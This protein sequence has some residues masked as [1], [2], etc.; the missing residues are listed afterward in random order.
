MTAIVGDT[1][2]LIHANDLE[3]NYIDLAEQNIIPQTRNIENSGPLFM[4]H[5]DRH[6]NQPVYV[7]FI[8]LFT[9]DVS[10]NRSKSWNKHINQYFAHRNLP[11][12]IVNQEFHVHFAS[13]S[14][15]VSATEQFAAIKEMIEET[16][17]DP[18]VTV[19]AAT[20]QL[21]RVRLCLISLAADNPMA[22]E[23]GCHIGG[24][25]NH[26]CRRCDVGGTT[27]EKMTE[28]GYHSLFAP[29]TPRTKLHIIHALKRQVESL[30]FDTESATSRLQTLSGIK[31]SF[32]T[33]G[34]RH[35]I[36]RMNEMQTTHSRERLQE[37]LHDIVHKPENESMLFNPV[38]TL[39]GFD[40]AIDTPIEILHTILLGIVKY[41]WHDTY[42]NVLS[43]SG[44]KER[45]FV[46]HLKCINRKGLSIP[47]I[48]AEYIMKYGNSLIGRHFRT[49]VQTAAFALID[50]KQLDMWKAV[51][52]LSGLVWFPS[53]I[54]RKVYLVRLIKKSPVSRY[55]P[56]TGDISAIFR[57]QFTMR[58][59]VSQMQTPEK[60][61]QRSNSIY[62]VT[63]QRMS[64]VS[65]LL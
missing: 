63:F 45:Q 5:P 46:E 32:D 17:K 34:M 60:S 29:A 20:G 47:P 7:S 49:L 31:G 26:Y 48:K 19:D 53:I 33:R 37:V 44:W 61:S 10:G 64:I 24:K 43:K 11:R 14:Q 3:L 2:V 42:S 25:G 55:V 18:I 27:E 9:D 16:W 30:C 6:L 57:S 50:A 51:G 23:I 62:F 41:V 13:T 4:P 56:K 12:E 8:E 22:S 21:I 38:L 59:T 28:P 52:E 65:A 1:E 54:D 39:D 35:L 36:Q 15:Q 58:W 40:P